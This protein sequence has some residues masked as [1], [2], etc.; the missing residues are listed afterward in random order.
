MVTVETKLNSDHSRHE[1]DARICFRFGIRS[2]L[3]L[4]CIRSNFSRFAKFGLDF[5]TI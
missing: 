5:A 2:S 4:N 3:N 1:E